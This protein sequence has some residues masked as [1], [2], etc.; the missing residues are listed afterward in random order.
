MDSLTYI[1][2]DFVIL[3]IWGFNS[4]YY[5]YGFYELLFIAL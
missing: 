1:Y 5:R 3:S 2:R 4:L